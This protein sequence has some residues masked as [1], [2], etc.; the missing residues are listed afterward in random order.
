[1]KKLL[2]IPVILLAACAGPNECVGV[3]GTD[4]LSGFWSGLWNGL[5]VGF[6]FIGSLF[7]D[8]ISIYEVHNTGGWYDFGFMLGSGLLLGSSIKAAD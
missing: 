3:A 2:I 4:G 1:M 8:N 7:T 6:A 5:T